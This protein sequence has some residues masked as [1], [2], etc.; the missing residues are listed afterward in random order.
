MPPEREPDELRIS[1]KLFLL[2]LL[3]ACVA[4][5]LRLGRGLFRLLD[6]VEGPSG[7]RWERTP[8]MEDLARDLEQARVQLWEA[9]R[10]R[11]E[12]G[13]HLRSRT[14][15]VERVAREVEHCHAKLQEMQA[16]LMVSER[17]AAVG[18]LTA[19][20]AHE[21]NNPLAF[22]LANLHFIKEAVTN[23]LSLAP[24]RPN[25][26][27]AATPADV[28]TADVLTA[29]EECLGGAERVREIVGDLKSYS[30][31]DEH[32]GRV[33]LHKVL[34][35]TITMARTQLKHRAQLV[36]EDGDVPEVEASGGR[37]AQVFLNL[38]V[39]AV[40]AM[41]ERD[42]A[43]NVIRVVT[44][45]DECGRAVVEI[46]DNGCGMS[47][48]VKGRIFEPF[49]TTK[50]SGV[51]TGLGLSI[52]RD[53]VRSLGGEIS[54]ESEM[55]KGSVFRVVL[56]AAGSEKRQERDSPPPLE[57][58]GLAYWTL[59]EREYAPCVLPKPSTQT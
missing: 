7:G 12:L 21:I 55:G 23:D 46:A 10:A 4:L 33:D 34:E 45:T 6:G 52:S 13:A 50:P 29:I 5:A 31:Q 9:T 22:I 57:A 53:I 36:R 32:Q 17:I 11:E 3:S 26:S 2:N 49:F 8:E 54:F 25:G 35:S 28:L 16:Q 14:A 41:P 59:T 42:A 44:R 19:I 58:R 47:P 51:G 37:L 43:R 20:V 24:A 18:P 15:E 48:E 56:A 30:R 1:S 40:Q 27:G 38:L 39:N